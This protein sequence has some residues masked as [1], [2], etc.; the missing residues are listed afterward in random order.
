A[1]ATGEAQSAG[2][3]STG[4]A[5]LARGALATPREADAR[6]PVQPAAG[7]TGGDVR[8]AAVIAAAQPAESLAAPERPSLSAA[9]APVTR[10]L[11]E[12][13]S[14]PPVLQGELPGLELSLG[15]EAVWRTYEFCPG[16]LQCGRQVF[17]GPAGLR[18]V[19][20]APYVGGSLTLT[21]FPFQ[22][23]DP[24]LS[25]LGFE[26]RYARRFLEVGLTGSTGT[27]EYHPAYDEEF[28]GE[29]LFRRSFPV[30]GLEPWHGVRLGLGSR[31]FVTGTGAAG[32]DSVRKL[33]A[34]MGL[35]GGVPLWGRWLTL[36]AGVLYAFGL[37]PGTA[38]REA[39][40]GAVVG[41]DTLRLRGGL[42]G[43]FGR[44]GLGYS[45][46]AEYGLFQDSFF[47]AGTRVEGGSARE[48][49]VTLTA[50]LRCAF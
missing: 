37:S 19:T 41:S 29:L 20:D 34:G 49:F 26:G 2:G 31:R 17:A 4:E 7:S 21:T 18:F 3:G 6:D 5:P 43:R 33:G 47:G 25:G 23:V 15:T 35:E 32:T 10:P 24:R 46:R 11:R 38:E 45:V 48:E 27:V 36:E 50:G 9:S 42:S 28:W 16:S 14:S 1:E 40:G 12:A 8:P 13:P 39:H 44:A 30:L 22:S